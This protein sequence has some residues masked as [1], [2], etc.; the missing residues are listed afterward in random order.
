[1]RVSPAPEEMDIDPDCSDYDI[2]LSE[3]ETEV[4]KETA[5]LARNFDVETTASRPSTNLN[6]NDILNFSPFPSSR[7]SNTQKTTN[8]DSNINLTK[9]PHESRVPDSLPED[10]PEFSDHE[11]RVDY[12]N[13]DDSESDNP[14]SSDSCDYD[15][16]NSDILDKAM[17]KAFEDEKKSRRMS[18]ARG[19]PTASMAQKTGI[20]DLFRSQKIDINAAIES[21]NIHKSG[22]ASRDRK[23]LDSK[24]PR[25]ITDSSNNNEST[26]KQSEKQSENRRSQHLGGPTKS[27]KNRRQSLSDSKKAVFEPALCFDDLIES[28]EN[29]GMIRPREH[30]SEL[31]L[32]F[33]LFIQC[34]FCALIYTTALIITTA[35]VPPGYKKCNMGQDN[36]ILEY[37]IS[38]I[39]GGMVV[40]N[41][42]VVVCMGNP[43]QFMHWQSWV[44]WHLRL[45][46]PWTLAITLTLELTKDNAE[47]LILTYFLVGRCLYPMAIVPSFELLRRFLG[48]ED[49]YRPDRI[50]SVGKKKDGT[51]GTYY[52]LF[53]SVAGFMFMMGGVLGF[54][55]FV[56]I[57]TGFVASGEW[58]ETLKAVRPITFNFIKKSLYLCYMRGINMLDHPIIGA[59]YLRQYAMPWIHLQIA[60][61]TCISAMNCDSW[62]TFFTFW[63]ADWLAFGQ[64]LFGFSNRW[65]EIP[66]VSRIRLFLRYGKP[67]AVG[68]MHLRRLR[69]WDTVLEGVILQ[70]GYL[71]MILFYPY[72]QYVLGEDSPV[73]QFFFPYDM[74]IVGIFLLSAS[75]FIQDG[76][77]I[78]YVEK[79][80]GCSYSFALGQPLFSRQSVKFI[81]AATNLVWTVCALGIIPYIFSQLELGVFKPKE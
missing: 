53:Y 45:C 32:H 26:A 7:V 2:N 14:E 29:A 63:V 76:I 69:G 38:N 48:Y 8:N 22:K 77:L 72:C 15:S 44:Y 37:H 66:I 79:V 71:T 35:V 34:M 56:V 75:D 24:S 68:T 12:D 23:N 31:K 59:G 28:G 17:Q 5:D 27:S 41:C 62:R 36:C 13:Y 51:I 25:K 46:I 18:M 33:Y 61:A 78:A 49:W 74:S 3:K 21:H 81:L 20:F 19:G 55:A 4:V 50:L 54:V 40:T 9:A 39:I 60:I 42:G 80:T 65:Q 1:M 67:M 70:A 16:D 73:T 11:S 52:E 10:I 6:H 64:R 43:H 47:E 57:D 58:G 30:I